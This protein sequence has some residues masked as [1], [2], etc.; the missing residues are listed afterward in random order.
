MA[1]T[2]LNVKQLQKE[3]T[4]EITYKALKGIDFHLDENE[5]V[6]VM[7]PSGSGKTT[8]LNCISTID[9]PTNGF[10]TINSKSPYELNDEELA[11]FRRT[12]LGFVFQDFNLVHT[13]T[14]E[15]NILLPL[16]LDSVNE[17]EMRRR[18][19]EIANFLGIREILKKRTFEI[20]GGQKQRVA[21]ARAVIHEPS[22]L[23]ADEPTGNLDSKSVNSVMTLFESINKTF[24]TAIL[25]VTHD[26]YV[27]SFAQRVIFIKDGVLYNEIHRGENKQQFYQ[28][29][30]DTLT[31]LGGG[32][33]EL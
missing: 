6:A 16:A 23:L 3:Y 24:N 13:L 2:I 4:G 22:L 7:G 11:K 9:R 29:I 28:E 20:S 8:F 30:M 31:F 25:M 14:I 18:L 26:A 21:I 19:A 10:I 15:E 12:E 33:H 27:A 32:R 17:K 1:E 5:F